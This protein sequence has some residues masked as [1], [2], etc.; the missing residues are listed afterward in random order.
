MEILAPGCDADGYLHIRLEGQLDVASSADLRSALDSVVGAAVVLID[1]SEVSFLDSAGLGV[2]IGSIR[3]FRERGTEVA[4]CAT[5]GHV[6][7]VLRTTGMGRIVDV[8]DDLGSALE[9]IREQASP[10]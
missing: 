10:A 6:Y 2:L 8:F 9:A 3:R 4:L 1:L 7:R 5:P